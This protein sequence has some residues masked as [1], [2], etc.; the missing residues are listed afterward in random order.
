MA[1]TRASK[2]VRPVPTTQQSQED[3]RTLLKKG[4]RGNLGPVSF[5]AFN[6][7]KAYAPANQTFSGNDRRY[8]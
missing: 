5:R 7:A 4:Y 8:Q 6:G 1:T 3:V 2:I